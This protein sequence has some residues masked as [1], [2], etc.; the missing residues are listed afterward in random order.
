M[1]EFITYCGENCLAGQLSLCHVTYGLEHKHYMPRV[2]ATK[3]MLS[4]L[5]ATG[6]T[7][8]DFSTLLYDLKYHRSAY[9]RGGHALVQ[10]YKRFRSEHEARAVLQQL[11]RARYVTAEK[12]GRR[13]MVSLTAK[14][15]FAILATQLKTTRPRDDKL[16]T[17]VIFDIPESQSRTRRQ[18]RLLL[19]QGG[20]TKLQQSVWRSRGDT[21]RLLTQFI[22]QA[23]LERWINIFHAKDFLSEP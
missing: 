21:H 17:V 20:F 10:E 23:K 12:T 15:R 9:V 16:S 5:A 7:V 14:G 13:L 1:L 6:Q 11:K 2:P 22:K 3:F 19:R 8:V 4:L 18:L